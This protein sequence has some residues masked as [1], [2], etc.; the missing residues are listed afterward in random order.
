MPRSNATPAPIPARRQG[1]RSRTRRAPRH[2]SPRSTQMAPRSATHR[3]WPGRQRQRL[4]VRSLGA[5][6]SGAI[7]MFAT[8][9]PLVG[10]RPVP[11]RARENV[12]AAT[13]RVKPEVK[14]SGVGRCRAPIARRQLRTATSFPN[15]ADAQRGQRCFFR[16]AFPGG[17]ATRAAACR[18]RAARCPSDAERCAAARNPGNGLKRYSCAAPSRRPKPTRSNRRPDRGQAE[19]LF[20]VLPTGTC[21][22]RVCAMGGSTRWVPDAT[23][24]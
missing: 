3:R 1:A 5:F 6:A 21:M 9:E 11:E 24:S 8:F 18:R 22:A 4:P 19:H 2:K 15:R 20:D 16:Q 7:E 17:C 12:D 13:R 10:R 14:S 23:P